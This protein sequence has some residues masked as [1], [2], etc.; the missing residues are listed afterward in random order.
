MAYTT[1]ADLMAIRPQILQ[2]G[3][4]SW[5]QYHTDAAT[6]VDEV[7]EVRWYRGEADQRGFNYTTTPFDGDLL[8][9]TQ[10]KKLVAYKVLELCYEYL[11][12]EM[13]EAD[14]FE[15]FMK[16]YNK[17]YE[18]ELQRLL[19]LGLHYDWDEDDTVDQDEKFAQ[20]YRR[21]ARS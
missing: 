16:L 1:D 13:S 5:D 8:D 6:T 21:L 9:T 3:V 15:R 17:R 20:Q 18:N 4:E 12:K 2:L 19:A 11:M 10:I 14:G 7:L